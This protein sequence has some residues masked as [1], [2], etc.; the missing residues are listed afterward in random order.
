VALIDVKFAVV[1]PIKLS[2]TDLQISSAISDATFLSV[3]FSL[4]SYKIASISALFRTL[5]PVTFLKALVSL[6]KID[7]A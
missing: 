6:P 5:F 1:S 2:L 7:F 3:R 4:N